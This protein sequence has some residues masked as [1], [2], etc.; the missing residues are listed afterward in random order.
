MVVKTNCNQCNKI[1]FNKWRHLLRYHSLDDIKTEMIKIGLEP[2]LCLECNELIRP[3]KRTGVELPYYNDN[4]KICNK[5]IVKKR[6]LCKKCEEKYKKIS[7]KEWAF[8]TFGFPLEE[9]DILILKSNKNK[10]NSLETLKEKFGEK[11]GKTLHK[12]W[13]EK[14]KFD[15]S[16]EGYKQRYGNEHGEIKFKKDRKNR[17]IKKEDF[18]RRHGENDGL[19]KYKQF[20]ESC[21]IHS[22]KRKERLGSSYDESFEKWKNRKNVL[23]I[24]YFLEKTNGNLIKAK[25]LQSDRQ[26]FDKQKFIQN[27]GKTNGENRYKEYI[28][29]KLSG[30]SGRS[31]LEIKLFQ[32]IYSKIKNKYKNIY[33][34]DKSY[35]F[36]TNKKFRILTGNKVIIPD[37]YIDDIDLVIELYGDFWHMNPNKY[38]KYDINS[39]TEKSAEETWKYDELKSKCI[40]TQY[41]KKLIIVW[42][43]NLINNY[44]RCFNEILNK[45]NKHEKNFTS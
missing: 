6:I 16:L 19:L 13:I 44:E 7:S 23:S 45:I 24:D 29:R 36:F 9:F 5:S 17:E 14:Q 38:K 20:K 37:F 31:S 18:I 1:Y 2:R 27:Y 35:M 8:R 4:I 30:F 10:G 43:E 21:S 41:K 3:V 40:K 28:K 34:N 25:K 15:S 32:D 39:V 11:M 33:W 26:R 42:E 22:L 12:K